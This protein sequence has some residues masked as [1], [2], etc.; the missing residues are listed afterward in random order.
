ML[1]HC[2]CLQSFV[3]AATAC[4]TCVNF[5]FLFFSF[6]ENLTSFK[7]P[8][9]AKS[10]PWH[11]VCQLSLT[12]GLQP[13][14]NAALRGEGPPLPL[15]GNILLHM[16]LSAALDLICSIGFISASWPS[17][18][19]FLYSLYIFSFAQNGTKFKSQRN[20]SEVWR[21]GFSKI[22]LLSYLIMIRVFCVLLFVVLCS[23]KMERSLD[24]TEKAV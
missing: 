14:S 15:L 6:H 19:W 16:V 21:K 11:W 8:H 22:N 12:V 20:I 3:K 9:V 7:R 23:E 2:H 5:I 1:T 18:L 10:N 4:C 17:G 13:L 24:M